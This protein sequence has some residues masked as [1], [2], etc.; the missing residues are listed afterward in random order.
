MQAYDPTAT[1]HIHIYEMLDVLADLKVVYAE[2]LAAK[3]AAIPPHIRQALVEL[4]VMY[5]GKLTMCQAEM[6]HLEAAIKASVLVLGT[7]VK[8]TRLHAVYTQG[9][10]SWDNAFLQG[11]AAVHEEILQGRKEGQ[12]SVSLRQAK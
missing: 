11:Y 6:T 3:E 10:V 8:G 5:H 2:T 7:S 12:A 4:D 9:R 1:S